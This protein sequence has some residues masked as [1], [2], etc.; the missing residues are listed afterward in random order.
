MS[1]ITII[2][3]LKRPSKGSELFFAFVGAIGT[4]IAMIR[5]LLQDALGR[6]SYSVEPIKLSKIIKKYGEDIDESDRFQ[7]YISLMNAGTN[8]RLSARTADFLALLAIVE[9]DE[10]RTELHEKSGTISK[11]LGQ[12]QSPP[13]PYTAY[14]FDQLKRKEEIDTLRL[15]YGKSLYVIGA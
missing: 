3:S 14:V 5:E 1:D 13:F 9:V 2:E 15:I 6:V 4:D 11:N 7:H 10:K 8:L 12:E